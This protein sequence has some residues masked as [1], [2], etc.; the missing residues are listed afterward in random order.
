MIIIKRLPDINKEKNLPKEYTKYGRFW[1]TNNIFHCTGISSSH[2]SG[3]EIGGYWATDGDNLFLSARGSIVG[4]EELVE[5]IKNNRVWLNKLISISGLSMKRVIQEELDENRFSSYIRRITKIYLI[6][7]LGNSVDAHNDKDA[8]ELMKN[9]VKERYNI[10][11]EIIKAGRFGFSEKKGW[12]FDDSMNSLGHPNH[13]ITG[14]RGY[15]AITNKNN[16][17]LFPKNENQ[18]MNDKVSNSNTF[19][20]D[21]SQY[22]NSLKKPSIEILENLNQKDIGLNFYIEKLIK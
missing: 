7:G 20:K 3:I 18:F 13:W 9:Q 15:Y 1:I 4:F 16:L 10:S 8:F 19:I 2:P 22:L 5:E 12:S 14:S 6:E 11:V 21:F 17:L